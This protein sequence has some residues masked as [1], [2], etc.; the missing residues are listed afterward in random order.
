MAV[1]D[2]LGERAEVL[3]VGG[4]GGMEEQLVRRAGLAFEAIP[5]AGVH[6]VGL[7]T[8]PGNLW[9][10]ATGTLAARAVLR[11]FHPDV[12]F[13][14]GGYVGIP[15]V[16]AGRRVPKVVFVPDIEPAL[17]SRLISR[18]ADRVCVSTEDSV[19]YYGSSERVRIT[20]YPTRRSFGG[21]TREEGRRGLGLSLDRPVV[22]VQGGS[23][24][25][26]SINRALW[27]ILPGLLGRAQVI[28]LT[29]EGEWPQVAREQKKLSPGHL[30]D[31]HP[32]P[33]LHDEMAAALVSADMVVSR[34]GASALGEYPVFG[35]PA[36]LVPYPHA[37]RYQKVNAQYLVDRGAA[38]Q[39]ADEELN[40][41]LWP[42]LVELLDDQENLAAMSDAARALAKPNAPHA[43]ADEILAV[44]QREA[45][46]E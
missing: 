37:W 7:W 15:M 18:T 14:T 23:R 19:A 41:G 17:A 1:I 35:L 6:G 11:R 46:A 45:R 16:L 42:A 22:L 38:I 13:F 39:L 21:L 10:L 9:R 28:H 40:Q 32:Y 12:I 44:G 33:Y 36:I 2:A 3:W 30:A 8:L 24:G 43:I 4:L 27:R 25:A 20:G 31:Y 5:A 34:A 26:R 29:G